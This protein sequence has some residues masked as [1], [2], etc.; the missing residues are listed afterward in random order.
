MPVPQNAV[1]L[2]G[3]AGAYRYRLQMSKIL[4]RPL[5]YSHPWCR[6]D[7]GHGRDVPL[8]DHGSESSRRPGRK[9]PRN[10]VAVR[11]RPEHPQ[12]ESRQRQVQQQRR[13]SIRPRLHT[14]RSRRAR[15]HLQARRHHAGPA[16][17]HRGHHVLTDEEKTPNELQCDQ[18]GKIF[19]RKATLRTARRLPPEDLRRDGV[20]PRS[21]L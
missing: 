7:A 1:L 16:P 21:V 3:D 15:G 2:V 18:C 11:V 8:R 14:C 5:L 6:S 12:V 20:E 19:T 13:H 10:E 17:I 4:A 9:L